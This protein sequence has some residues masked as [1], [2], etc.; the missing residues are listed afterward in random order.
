[1]TNHAEGVTTQL[2]DQALDKGLNGKEFLSRNLDDPDQIAKEVVAKIKE[3]TATGRDMVMRNIR[4]ALDSDTVVAAQR[5]VVGTVRNHPLAVMG[6]A[7]VVGLVLGRL[8][9]SR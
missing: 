9:R 6:G 3:A 2:R 1:M 5:Q 4:A 8:L 7:V